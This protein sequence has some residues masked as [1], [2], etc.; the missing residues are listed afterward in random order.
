MTCWS[1]SRPVLW[2]APALAF[3]SLPLMIGPLAIGPLAIGP[4]SAQEPLFLRIRPSDA[5]P[6]A[7]GSGGVDPEIAA[8]RAAREAV[9]E[10]STVR[11]NIAIA[12]VCTGC[13]GRPP[14]PTPLRPDRPRPATPPE[15]ARAALAP[16]EP[17]PDAAAG[18]AADPTSTRGD[19]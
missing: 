13:L 16:A 5:P 17:S 2:L 11:A 19:P 3:V 6:P 12:S 18:P 4:A 9:W 14:A 7:I 10:R 1:D 15:S 8:A